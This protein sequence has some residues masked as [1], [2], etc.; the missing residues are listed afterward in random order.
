MTNILMLS[1]KITGRSYAN[2]K[3]IPFLF[4]SD[5][6]VGWKGL[7]HHQQGQRFPFVLVLDSSLQ[8][9][10]HLQ[11]TGQLL[12]PLKI[13]KGY[14]KVE[15]Y[16]FHTWFQVMFPSNKPIK[17]CVAPELWS[18]HD[19][20]IALMTTTNLRTSIHISIQY[21]Y[22]TLVSWSSDYTDYFGINDAV[23]ALH[24]KAE[25][26]LRSVLPLKMNFTFKKMFSRF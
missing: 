20:V 17:V 16:L 12:V 18:C 3:L 23:S 7:R 25:M 2:L 1:L 19:I 15:R 13:R 22:N 11:H 4:S 6:P 14:V 21:S 9:F 10:W 26:V 24:S 5:L 8:S